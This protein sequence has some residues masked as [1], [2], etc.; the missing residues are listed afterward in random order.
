MAGKLNGGASATLG[1]GASNPPLTQAP[2]AATSAQTA[3]QIAFGS[4][5]PSGSSGKHPF[6]TAGGHST[7]FYGAVVGLVGLT[8]LYRSLPR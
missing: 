1:W 3:S 7:I 4:S 8:L 6:L 5:T 2:Q